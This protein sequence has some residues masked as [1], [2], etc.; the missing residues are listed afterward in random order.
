M[1][2]K[3]IVEFRGRKYRLNKECLCKSKRECSLFVKGVCNTGDERWYCKLP[4]DDL[5][6]ATKEAIGDWFNGGFQEVK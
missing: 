4:C 5:S 3:V 1:K 2:A 6:N